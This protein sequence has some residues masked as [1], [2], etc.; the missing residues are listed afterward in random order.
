MTKAF[1]D[2]TLDEAEDEEETEKEE[3]L[4]DFSEDDKENDDPMD[5]SESDNEF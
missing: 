5:Y 1:D 2:L 4:I 3:I